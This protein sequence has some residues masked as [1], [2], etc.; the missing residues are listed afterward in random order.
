MKEEVHH[1]FLLP[2]AFLFLTFLKSLSDVR[3]VRERCERKGREISKVK[4]NE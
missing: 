4:G 2:F 3:E 1:G